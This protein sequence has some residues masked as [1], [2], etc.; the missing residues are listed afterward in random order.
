MPTR[1]ERAF[2]LAAFD[3]D[4]VFACGECAGAAITAPQL[5]HHHLMKEAWKS[6]KNSL[7]V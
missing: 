3:L 5:N 6:A 1:V 2:L 4:F 7:Q